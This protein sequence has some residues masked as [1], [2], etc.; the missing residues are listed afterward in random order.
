VVERDGE[1]Y[2][3]RSLNR[4][5]KERAT[6]MRALH[7]LRKDL[8]KLSN[9]VRS[10]RVRRREL[11]Y[12]RLGRLEERWPTAW[13]YLKKVELTDSNLVWSCD[14]KK[15]RSAWLHHGTYLLRTNLTD[16]DPKKLWRQYIQLTESEAVFRTLKTELNLRPIFHRIQRRVEAHILIAFLVYC[17]W[18]CLKQ[19]LRAAAGSLTPAQVVHSLKQIILV[20]VWFDLRKRAEFVCCASPIPKPS[21]N[22]SLYHLGW[23][24]PEQPPPKI[25]R[26]QNQFVWTT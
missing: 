3:C 1:L 24:L 19:K 13:P 10:G 20:E 22:L 16:R 14:R 17:L 4:A 15:L 9:S 12:K 5:E 8:A 6:R 11:I 7:G 18:V 2:V 21:N 25:Y 23:S 26:D